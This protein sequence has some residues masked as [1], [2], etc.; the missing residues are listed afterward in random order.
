MNLFSNLPEHSRSTS[1]WEVTIVIVTAAAVTTMAC[2]KNHLTVSIVMAVT[3]ARLWLH[4]T[5]DAAPLTVIVVWALL[6]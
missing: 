2:K 3:I 1:L 5:V 4:R 6:L